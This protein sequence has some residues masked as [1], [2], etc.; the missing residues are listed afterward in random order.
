[1]IAAAPSAGKVAL[2]TGGS[3]GIG[4]GIAL[5]LMRRGAAVALTY[6]ENDKLAA[7][8]AAEGS[9]SGARCAVFQMSVEDRASV[10]EV[11]ERVRAEL[12]PVNV[13]VNNA[14]IAQEK[15]FETI[16][17]EDWD[18][19]LAVNLR[20]PF[21]CCQ[22]VLPDM[23]GEGWGRIVNIVSIG[24]QWGGLNQVHYAAAKAGLINLTRSLAR[25]YGAHGITVNAVA[26]GLVDTEMVSRELASKAGRE[27]VQSIPL[28]RIATV[29]EVASVV[30]FLAGEEASYVTGQT[31]SVNGGMYFG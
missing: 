18:R 19:V 21:A 3:R 31:L 7:E 22:E 24:G 11:V 25:I 20:G 9:A 15:S 30:A 14:A 29:E 1:M 6:R 23:V 12:G 13:L 8:V 28:G 4:R 27:K 26:P 10:R 17:D 5:E 2:V 16:S